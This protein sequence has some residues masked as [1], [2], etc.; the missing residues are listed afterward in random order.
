MAGV[1]APGKQMV[2]PGL[3]SHSL[4]T[5]PVGEAERSP[6]VPPSPGHT[7]G[8]DLKDW[9]GGP[10]QGLRSGAGRALGSSPLLTP[11]PPT[12]SQGLHS[13]GLAFERVWTSPGNLAY[14]SRREFSLQQ[15]L[16]VFYQKNLSVFGGHMLHNAIWHECRR[17]IFLHSGEKA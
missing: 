13:P 11:L 3:A 8:P 6:A 7:Q 1:E 5:R 9:R 2:E 14:G 17:V 10:A 12:L 15:P 16:T 4:G